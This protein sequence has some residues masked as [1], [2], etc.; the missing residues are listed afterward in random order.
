M[1]AE[2]KISKPRKR[3]ATT[4]ARAKIEDDFGF[5]EALEHDMEETKLPSASRDPARTVPD[6]DHD[7]LPPA[8]PSSKASV[9]SA[10]LSDDDTLPPTPPD[11]RE[12]VRKNV[13]SSLNA[14]LAEVAA[15]GSGPKEPAS[16]GPAVQSIAT[17]DQNLKGIMQRIA[18]ALT[19][20]AAAQFG[21]LAIGGIAVVLVWSAVDKPPAHHVQVI[22]L[23]S[24]EAESR[25]FPR[26]EVKGADQVKTED[27]EAMFRNRKRKAESRADERL[28][29]AAG[30]TSSEDPNAKGVVV[31]KPGELIDPDAPGGVVVV[32]PDA[33][34]KARARSKG[35]VSS[36]STEPASPNTGRFFT[37]G[38]LL[39]GTVEPKSG[40]RETL[41]LRI[42]DRFKAKLEVG[43]VSSVREEVI[44]SVVDDVV[45]DGK[46]VLKKG[47][48]LRG[49]TSNDDK[50]IFI[51]FQSVD[52]GGRPL[53]LNAYA[54][55]KK[56]PGL[57][58]VRREA[59][60]EEKSKKS[61]A[62]GAISGVAREAGAILAEGSAV[63]RIVEGAANGVASEAQQEVK[64]DSSW[65]LEVPA[66]KTFEVVVTE[67]SK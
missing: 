65:V 48:M 30:K 56:M 14:I 39:K 17:D 51:R 44:A 32:D 29:N 64:T 28:E 13:E 66:G 12:V 38:G 24:N 20:S 54:V 22:P 1:R 49:R 23:R 8:G 40:A 62:S 18:D 15:T 42:G 21:G 6:S 60:L 63:G 4:K 58:A 25:P 52:C 37:P 7:T 26:L 36:K 45:R 34:K 3:R 9:K 33:P 53:A 19:K 5:A 43:I 46:R 16:T 35:R 55:E 27:V 59:T 41:A 31:L 2:A 67:A 10:P 61:A 47:D 11:P 50:R 57:R